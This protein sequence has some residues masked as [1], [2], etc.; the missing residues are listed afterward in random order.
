M[1]NAVRFIE[2][3]GI[4]M[5]AMLRLKDKIGDEYDDIRNNVFAAD[6]VYTGY[7]EV[8]EKIVKMLKEKAKEK[9]KEEKYY[10]PDDVINLLRK[11]T[12]VN[13]GDT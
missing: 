5:T 6:T 10:L 2:R 1:K 3:R 7:A 11:I 8:I 4:F 13:K 12:H 9:G